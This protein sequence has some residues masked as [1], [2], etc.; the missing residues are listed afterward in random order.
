M[1]ATIVRVISFAVMTRDI[2]EEVKR[3][4]ADITA[5]MRAMGGCTQSYRKERRRA[6]KAMFSEVYSPPRV[7][8]ACKLLP[9][10]KVIPDHE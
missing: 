8:A 9:D 3:N 7:A 1:R 10:F 4:E 2:K 5:T 6:V